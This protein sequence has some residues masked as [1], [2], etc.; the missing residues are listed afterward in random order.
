MALRH[1]IPARLDEATK[2]EL[3]DALAVEIGRPDDEAAPQS[4]PVVYV[5][6]GDPP[7][8]YRHWFA[9]WDRFEGV[10]REERCHILM[11]SIRQ[12]L[13]DAEALKATMVLGLT[14]TEAEEYGL[15]E[16]D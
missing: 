9:V 1:I 10:D 16:A 13:G 8:K 5:E 7:D 14:P 12:S 11:Q 3:V 6:D 4:A 15:T 2:A